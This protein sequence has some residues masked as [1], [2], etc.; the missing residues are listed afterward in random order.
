MDLFIYE[1]D[2]FIYE[3]DLFIYEMDLF[4]LGIGDPKSK[5]V[6]ALAHANLWSSKHE[7]KKNRMYDCM[8]V[9]KLR[10]IYVHFWV[11]TKS[12]FFQKNDISDPI[13]E[14][15]ADI[16]KQTVSYTISV[17]GIP[18][19]APRGKKK[20]SEKKISEKKNLWWAVFWI[21]RGYHG[22]YFGSQGGLSWAVF[23]SQGGYH[24]MVFFTCA[25]VR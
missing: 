8:V 23:G 21:A 24:H 14:E 10:L 5:V 3:M 1:T 12:F 17:C 19:S 9:A 16:V 15:A 22:Q 11:I 13:S 18:T 20:I 7:R 4:Q 6:W 2:L 25:Y